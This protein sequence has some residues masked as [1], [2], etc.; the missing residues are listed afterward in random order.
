MD[1]VCTI[2]RARPV[3]TGPG[4]KFGRKPA[5]THNKK[6]NFVRRHR[7]T[8]IIFIFGFCRFPAELGP[9][10]RS[11]GSGSKDGAERNENQPRRPSLRPFRDHFPAGPTL[12]FP[13]LQKPHGMA[14]ECILRAESR[15]KSNGAP[16]SPKAILGPEFG[17]FAL[18]LR[19]TRGRAAILSNLEQ[20]GYG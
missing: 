13:R 20:L 4:A 12:P 1:A 15:C 8:I 19:P 11:N 2:F 6:C 17:L 14:L 9:E 3:G 18:G 5:Q 7:I 16:D 10:T